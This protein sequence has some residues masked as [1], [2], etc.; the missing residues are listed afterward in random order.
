[1]CYRSTRNGLRSFYTD[2]QE[3]RSAEKG[4]V[5]VSFVTAMGLIG[6]ALVSGRPPDGAEKDPLIASIR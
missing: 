2:S 5:L 3:E 1:M 4:F 6:C